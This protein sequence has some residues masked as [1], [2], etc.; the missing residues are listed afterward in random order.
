MTIGIAL[1]VG[2]MALSGT[3]AAQDWPQ[4]PAGLDHVAVGAYSARSPPGPRVIPSR[5]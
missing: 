4:W 3:V 2:V 1:V 5:T